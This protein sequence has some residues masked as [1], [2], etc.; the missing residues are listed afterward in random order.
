MQ[1]IAE[2]CGISKM[3][4]SL[5]LRGDPRVKST[6]RDKVLAEARKLGYRTNPYIATLMARLRSGNQRKYRPVIAFLNLQDPPTR[7]HA[8]NAGKNYFIGAR[9]RAEA[10]GF[11]LEEFS[12]FTRDMSYTRLEKVFRTRNIHAVL[13]SP[14][15]HPNTRVDLAWERYATARFGFT[16]EHPAV[17]YVTADHFQTVQTL[18]KELLR[19]G[20]RHLGLA[21]P[22]SMD[23]RVDHRW[24]G[25]FLYQ[26]WKRP[27]G[28]RFSVF[29][30]AEWNRKNFL[31][32]FNKEKPDCVVSFEPAIPEWLRAEGLRIPE[33]VGFATI[34]WSRDHSEHSGINPRPRRTGALAVDLVVEQVHRNEWGEP[35]DAKCV[36]VPGKWTEGRTLQPRD[37]KNN[38][39]IQEAEHLQ[40]DR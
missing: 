15:D 19:K 6:T 5:A 24:I 11:Q 39:L 33:E 20:Y 28:S 38:A 32:W 10:L 35:E 13:L 25:S 34:D 8:T 37:D 27:R 26:K 30:P 16:V 21:V 12:P 29:S 2:A 7:L 23:E 22:R 4:V 31:V 14:A 3:T 9:D 17:H 36:L 1:D 40:K 18:T